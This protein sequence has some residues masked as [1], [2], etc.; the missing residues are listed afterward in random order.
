MS[1]ESDRRQ[2]IARALDESQLLSEPIEQFRT[3]YLEAEQT[4]SAECLEVNAMTLATSSP[5]GH[6][7]ARVVL[8]KSFDEHGFT[9][10]T[11][12]ES[13]KGSQLAENPRAALVIYWPH[14]ERQVRIEG[15]VEKVSREESEFYFRSR[16][17]SSQISA[18]VSRQ[19]AVVGDRESFERAA[20]ELERQLAGRPIPLP[21]NWG[22]YRVVPLSIEFWQGRESRLHDRILYS[23][24]NPQSAW[25]R[26]RLAP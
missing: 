5:R 23:R 19:S 18:V 14:V 17:R 8:L 3:W 10:Y 9:F 13:V 2:Y 15:I 11:N 21:D 1:T 16:P 6:V 4:P 7:T 22:G 24:S 25:Q 26:T 20:A 12:Y